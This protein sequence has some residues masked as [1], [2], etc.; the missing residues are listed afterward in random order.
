MQPKSKDKRTAV[1]ID[2]KLMEYSS[3]LYRQTQTV[4]AKI[5][6]SDHPDTLF[7]VQHPNVFTLGRRGGRENLMVS[8]AFLEQKNIKVVQTDRGGN[9]TFHGPGQAVLYPIV[10]LDRNRIGVKDFVYGLEEVMKRTADFFDIRAER[11]VRNQGLWVKDAKI[12]SI[13]ISVKRGISFHGLALNIFPD[14]TPFS[15]INP[16]GLNDISMTSIENEAGASFKSS[17]GQCH[18]GM[19][20]K[21]FIKHFAAFFNYKIDEIDKDENQT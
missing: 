5:D 21:M 8:E 16:C 4:Q 6:N 9:I 15:W 3:A 13:G 18:M 20:K 11:D 10:D 14:L 12:G 19:V 7:F 17:N 2:L 1:F